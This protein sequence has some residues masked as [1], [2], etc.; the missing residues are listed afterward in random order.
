MGR[1]S[2][3]NQP[4]ADEIN[5]RLAKGESLRSICNGS[6]MPHLS[7]VMRW[8]ADPDRADFREQYA[9]AREVQADT[10]FDECL[11]IAD[12][13]SG[14]TKVT[15][16]GGEVCNTEFVQRAKLRIET[17]KWMVGK[18]APKKYGD[19]I[20]LTS[21]DGS[22]S[23]KPTIIEFVAPTGPDESDD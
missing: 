15:E 14:D 21:S 20:D 16:G 11:D 13:A 8:L 3:F 7:T 9:H 5:R 17:R 22:M 19:K 10:L 2:K 6:D 4:V 1:P 12:D 23:P 18:L